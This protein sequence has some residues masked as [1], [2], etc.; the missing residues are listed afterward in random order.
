MKEIFIALGDKGVSFAIVALQY[1]FRLLTLFMVGLGG[2][3]IPHRMLNIK[4]SYRQ[5]NSMA[6][7]LMFCWSWFIQW[8]FWWD[9]STMKENIYLPITFWIISS[10]PYVLFGW[11]L[12]KRM[13]NFLDRKFGKD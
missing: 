5:G 9:K 1:A 3:Y 2:V 7:I 4:M 8:V 6:L 11:R 10:I 13:D 12:Y